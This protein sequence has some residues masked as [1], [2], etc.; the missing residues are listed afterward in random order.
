M[1]LLSA[2]G[3]GGARVLQ[4]VVPLP[5]RRGNRVVVTGDISCDHDMKATGSEIS[6]SWILK[7]KWC[8]RR[9]HVASDA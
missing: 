1:Q 8:S 6:G 9:E 2:V 7:C 3:R 4:T 5:S